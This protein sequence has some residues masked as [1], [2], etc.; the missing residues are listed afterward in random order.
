MHGCSF[1]CPSPSFTQVSHVVVYPS[2][3]AVSDWLNPHHLGTISASG[4]IENL[5]LNANNLLNS[6][7]I[8][9][10]I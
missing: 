10:W 7:E 6:Q 5:A 8:D 3:E 1:W 2:Q 9:G 4:Y